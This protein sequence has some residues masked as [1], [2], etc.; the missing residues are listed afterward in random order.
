MD[1]DA[2]RRA[3]KPLHAFIDFDES[4]RGGPGVLSGMTVGVKS[5]VAVAGLPWTA[6]MERRRDVIAERDAAVVARLRA[7][8]AVILGTLNMHEAALGATTDNA[9]FGHT[10]NP[11]KLGYTPAGSSGGSGAAVAGG[12]CD[13]ALGTDTLGS[14]RLPAAY[15]G[16]YGLKPTKGAVEEEGLVYCQPDFDTIG[17]LTRSL[18]TLG[19]VWPAI[20]KDPGRVAPLRRI[21]VLDNL[22]GID[23]EPAVLKAFIAACESLD[24]PVTRFR[25]PDSATDIRLAGFVEAGKWLATDLDQSGEPRENRISARLKALLDYCDGAESRPDILARTRAALLDAL[26]EDGVLLTPTTPHVAFAHGSPAP[27][28][29]ADFTS[30]ANIAGVPA[31]AMPAGTNED[32]LP[33]SVQLVGPAHCELSL[34]A[35]AREIDRKLLAYRAPAQ[36][37]F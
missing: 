20:A 14:I 36:F 9:S 21:L 22:G 23:V 16:V 30:P 12:L 27:H 32:G 18:D 33:V 19:R 2:L 15:C 3:N 4:A 37:G 34:I 7:A 35:L 10:M 28:S 24:L 11:H 1:W 17:P 29:Q 8:G 13:M 6:G 25:F 31:L 5:N 26:G